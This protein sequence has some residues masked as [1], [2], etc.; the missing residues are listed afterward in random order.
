MFTFADVF[1]LLAHKLARLSGRRFAFAFVFTSAFDCFF[2]W[3]INV[4]SLLTSDLDV[5]KH[6]T[7]CKT[8][9]KT[10]AAIRLLVVRVLLG[11]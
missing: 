4:G 10:A 2:F 7:G 9:A 1:H 11:L 5:R 6:A 3:H 8:V